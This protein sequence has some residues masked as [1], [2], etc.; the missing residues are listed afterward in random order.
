MTEKPDPSDI[1]SLQA[2]LNSARRDYRALHGN[3]FSIAR[4]EAAKAECQRLYDM[5]EAMK[6]R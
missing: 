5:L 6:C 1:R 2:R 3:G 4:R